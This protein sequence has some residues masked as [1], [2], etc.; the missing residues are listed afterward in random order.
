MYEIKVNHGIEAI[1]YY[2][3]L[4]QFSHGNLIRSAKLENKNKS[5]PLQPTGKCPSLTRKRLLRLHFCTMQIGVCVYHANAPKDS[6]LKYK[7]ATPYIF[8]E[9]M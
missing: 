4:F 2:H 6:A 9:A 3:F 5:S 8:V 1:A 7:P